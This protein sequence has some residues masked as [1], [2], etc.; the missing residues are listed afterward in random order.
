VSKSFC[1]PVSILSVVLFSGSL[2][3]S[4]SEETPKPLRRAEVLAL[5]AGRALPDNVAHELGT[6]GISFVPSAE[7]RTQLKAAGAKDSIFAALDKAKTSGASPSSDKWELELLEHL[8]NASQRINAKKYTEA[9]EELTAA[10]RTSVSVPEAGF[11]MGAILREEEEWPQAAAVYTEVLRENPNFPQAHTKL[12]FILC[13]LDDPDSALREVKVALAA[14]P[15]DAEAHKNA[16][17]AFYLAG[18][19]DA[20]VAEYQEAL[21]LKKA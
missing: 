15:E 7:Y 21:R 19:V 5:V 14:N 11:V 13:R 2:T 18:K 4:A 10:L 6:R 1:F 12:S 16:G 17:L 20:S 8:T 3:Y 9:V